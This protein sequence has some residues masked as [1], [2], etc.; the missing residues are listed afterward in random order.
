MLTVLLLAAVLTA[1][2]G[3]R[4]ALVKPRTSR[5][6]SARRWDAS[7]PYKNTLPGVKYVGDKACTH[8]HAEIAETYRQHP[9]GRSLSPIATATVTGGDERNGRPL[10]EDQGLEY[11]IE[12]RDGRVIHKETRRNSSGRIIARNEG[13]VQYVLGSGRRGLTYLI[14][15]DGFLVESPITWYSQAGRWGLSPG[16]E[17]MNYHFDRPVQAACLFCHANRIEPVVGGTLN[18]YRPPIFQGHE[19]GCE[20]CH[21]PGELHVAHPEIIGGKDMT[22]VNPAES[23]TLTSGRRLRAVPPRRRP[24]HR[25]GRPPVRGLPAGS[26]PPSVLVGAGAGIGAGVSS[27]RRPGRADA[28]EPLLPRQRRRAWLYLLP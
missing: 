12:R 6:I 20:R 3:P 22:I 14:D 24:A 11:S 16:Y 17:E 26:S 27:F 4:A 7:S 25:A 9:M 5:T 18:R 21:G 1:I 10:F 15:R 13:E 2:L 19:I 28:R 23:G 8:C